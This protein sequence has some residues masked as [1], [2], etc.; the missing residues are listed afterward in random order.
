MRMRLLIL[1]TLALGLMQQA[2]AHNMTENWEAAISGA[3]LGKT[4]A[5][6]S[7]GNFALGYY[8]VPA[9]TEPGTPVAGHGEQHYYTSTNLTGFR[10]D[11]G[12]PNVYYALNVSENF[13]K[14]T[15]PRNVSQK[16]TFENIAGIQNAT[17]IRAWAVGTHVYAVP[18]PETYAL[19]GVGLLALMAK[20]RRRKKSQATAIAA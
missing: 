18:E 15:S 1:S 19:M 17:I 16:F 14:L 7:G 5:S 12:S 11:Y 8:A 13:G 6:L 10:F 3:V 2:S 20:T 9:V 4:F